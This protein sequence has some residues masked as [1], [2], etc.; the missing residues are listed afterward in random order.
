MVAC[1]SCRPQSANRVFALKITCAGLELLFVEQIFL[2][3]AFVV[4]VGEF[5]GV[6]H[7]DENEQR[8]IQ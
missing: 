5:L 7:V 4:I 8:E 6:L 3:I 2:R 1:W